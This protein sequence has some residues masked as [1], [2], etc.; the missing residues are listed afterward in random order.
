LRR[1]AYRYGYRCRRR[2]RSHRRLR[3]RNEW[4][5]IRKG[6]G[7]GGNL[8]WREDLGRLFSRRIR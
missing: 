8:G 4:G 7:R 5:R 6:R 1:R 3:S 2:L